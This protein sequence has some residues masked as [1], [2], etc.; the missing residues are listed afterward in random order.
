[1]LLPTQRPEAR[2]TASSHHDGIAV[3]MPAIPIVILIFILT[4][5]L[6]TAIHHCP[7]LGTAL[8]DLM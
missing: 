3:L 4:V 7:P 8:G 2:A 6:M 1:M 5:I